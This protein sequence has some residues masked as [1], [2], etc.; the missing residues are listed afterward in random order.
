M[1]I[2]SFLFQHRTKI[3]LV[4][5]LDHDN[6]METPSRSYIDRTSVCDCNPLDSSVALF[7]HSRKSIQKSP[8][9]SW[10]DLETW[11]SLFKGASSDSKS[12]ENVSRTSFGKQSCLP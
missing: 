12:H 5:G 3:T 11:P 2:S 4:Q 7:A 10:R 6:Q 8:C 9:I 1:G